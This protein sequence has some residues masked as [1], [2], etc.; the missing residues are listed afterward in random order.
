MLAQPPRSRF[1]PDQFNQKA[2]NN[3]IIIQAHIPSITDTSIKV[4]TH[5]KEYL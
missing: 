2:R 5:E 4:K 3:V 1:T